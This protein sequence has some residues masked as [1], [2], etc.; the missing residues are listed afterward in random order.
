MNE[1]KG[2]VLFCFSDAHLEDLKGSV[3]SYR[4][5][6]LLLMEQY[7]GDNYFSTDI[8]QHFEIFLAT[9]TEAYEGKNFSAVDDFFADPRSLD[10][11]F[12][13][14][15]GDPEI[16]ALKSILNTFL[17]SPLNNITSIPDMD[18]LDEESQKTLMELL[19]DY[20]KEMSLRQFWKNNLDFTKQFMFDK[21]ELTNLR[22]L[23]TKYFNRDDYSWDKWKSNFSKKLKETSLNKTFLEVLD[24][25]LVNDQKNKLYL[26]ILYGYTILE[27]YNI[28][29]ERTKRGLK[30]FTFDSLT[31]DAHH[32]YFASHSDY[33]VTDDKGLQLKAFILYQVFNIPTQVLSITD[34]LNL[35]HQING[36]EDTY[37]SFRKTLDHD[38]K[39]SFKLFSKPDLMEN[40]TI[41]TFKTIHTYFNYF[42]R[43]QIA[44]T[45]NSINFVLYCERRSHANFFL[46]REIELIINKLLAAFGEDDEKRGKYQVK[47]KSN[48]E[49]LRKWTIGGR[50]YELLTSGKNW[51]HFIC[52]FFYEQ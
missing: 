51:G 40:R 28:T 45:D 13:N 29:Q 52:L 16:N 1:L 11:L 15:G 30:K 14:L 43:L 18:S 49:Y 26:K 32:A 21:D 33:L 9:P 42:N 12:D 35:R 8:N 27:M 5:E 41:D 2:K 50:R 17:D 24:T 20:S 34:F 36:N 47:E 25:M 3:K 38:L 22:K 10:K 19:P 23:V 46:Y 6:D 44:K 4:D 31:R 39:H 37:E 48:E 7:V